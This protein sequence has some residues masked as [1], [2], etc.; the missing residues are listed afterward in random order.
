[1]IEEFIEECWF[2][3]GIKVKGTYIGFPVYHAA[4]TS[5]HVEFDW[6]KAMNPFL[7]GWVH[8]HLNDFGSRPSDTDNSTM[9]GWVRGKGK[10]LL[11]AILCDNEEGHYEYYRTP[12]GE[13][14]RKWLEM[15]MYFN[16]IIAKQWKEKIHTHGIALRRRIY[17]NKT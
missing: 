5:G 6:K 16:I 13:I 14:G 3:Y 4:G 9:R 1:M 11:C 2:I 10:P 12:E 15:R 17:E 8:T 7:L